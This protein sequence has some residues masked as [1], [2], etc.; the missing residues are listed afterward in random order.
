MEEEEILVIDETASDSENQEGVLA[1]IKQLVNPTVTIKHSVDTKSIV[2]IL[3]WGF[4]LWLGSRLFF[5]T[6]KKMIGA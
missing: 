2:N 3:L 1:A 4:L 5:A 6:Y